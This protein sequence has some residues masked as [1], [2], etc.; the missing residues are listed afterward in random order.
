M[1]NEKPEFVTI[2]RIRRTQGRVG[3][4]LADIETDFPERF[5]ETRAAFLLDR[6]GGRRAIQL[7]GH[8]FHKGAVV[9]KIAG[10]DDI[11]AAAQLAGCEVQIP[12]AERRTLGPGSVYISELE[13]CRVLEHGREIG[14]VRFLDLTVGTP[15]LVV[16]T[17]E[18]ELLIPFAEEY[19]K[20]IDTAAGSIEVELPEGL[21]ELNR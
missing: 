2:A 15:V 12:V 19:C 1:S 7:E 16:D 9:L 21:R 13:G 20:R 11:N 6:G 17:P 4:V 14:R 5:A 3:E 18:G 10:V 8:W